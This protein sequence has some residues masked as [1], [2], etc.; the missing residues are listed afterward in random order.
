[1]DFTPLDQLRPGSVAVVG[2]PWDENSSFMRGP[3]EGPA[4]LRHVMYGGSANLCAESGVDL[5]AE[6][7]FCWVEDL[8]LGSGNE[9]LGPW[10]VKELQCAFEWRFVCFNGASKSHSPTRIIIRVSF[11]EC[12]KAICYLQ[13]CCN[14]K[15]RV[16][17]YCLRKCCERNRRSCGCYRVFV[18]ETKRL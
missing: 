17:S 12:H 15:P 3:A 7:R 4:R 18:W 10:E 5:G 1:M 6:S 9:V 13:M 16:F 8:A 11:Y 2:I 14:L